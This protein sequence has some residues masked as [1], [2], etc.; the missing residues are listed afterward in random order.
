M[1]S[2]GYDYRAFP[3]FSGVSWGAIWAGIFVAMFTQLLLGMLGLALGLS[4][5][6][7]SINI[8]AKGLGIGT[9]LWLLIITVVSIFAGTFTTGRLANYT[10]KYDGVIHGIVT[11][12]F[13]V[14]LSIFLTTIGVSNAI[15]GTFTQAIQAAKLQQVQQA[16]PP[17]TLQQGVK[18]IQQSAQMTPEDQKKLASQIN[19]IATQAAWWTFF[20]GIIALITAMVGGHLGRIARMKQLISQGA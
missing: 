16:L 19:S 15:G 6:N 5:M 14:V 8:S 10:A 4:I 1:E 12:S 13:L 2:R 20:L 17:A 9:G 7:P 11:L 3:N 18:N